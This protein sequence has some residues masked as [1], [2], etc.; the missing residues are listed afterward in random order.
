MYRLDFFGE[1]LKISVKILLNIYQNVVGIIHKNFED[2]MKKSLSRKNIVKIKID[3]IRIAV[4][5]VIG[6]KI[7]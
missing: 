5:F 6:L 7:F 1:I 2:L 3:L 4:S